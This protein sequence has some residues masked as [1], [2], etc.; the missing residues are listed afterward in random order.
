[1]H[2]EVLSDP[3]ALDNPLA[4]GNSLGSLPWKEAKALCW[5]CFICFL[6]ALTRLVFLN[7]HMISLKGSN[8]A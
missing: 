8:F 4:L 3:L 7:L 1:M 6:L 5:A 2:L